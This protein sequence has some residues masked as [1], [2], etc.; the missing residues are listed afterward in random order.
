[1]T[2]LRIP[3]ALQPIAAGLH[4]LTVSAETV[5]DA[6]VHLIERFP[7]MRRH[8]YDDSGALRGFV[9]VYLND[10]D[11]R[12]L[13]EQ[14]TRVRPTDVITIVPSVAGGVDL[15]TLSVRELGRYMDKHARD[16]FGDF[17]DMLATIERIPDDEKHDRRAEKARDRLSKPIMACARDWN[18]FGEAISEDPKAIELLERFN[19][20]L[21]RTF[22]IIFGEGGQRFDV[23]QMPQRLL[24]KT[25]K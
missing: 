12:Y 13:E 16:I 21:G 4:E 2:T 8:L 18:R 24:A 7:A 14:G 15:P 20:R 1:M 23:L 9:N 5:G 11:V 17:G 10:Q 6:L 19:E 3:A 25:E 22:E